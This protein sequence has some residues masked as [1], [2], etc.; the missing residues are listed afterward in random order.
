M[1]LTVVKLTYGI[2]V[3]EVFK[4]LGISINIYS[5]GR[6]SII[7]YKRIIVEMFDISTCEVVFPTTI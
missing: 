1:Y 2:C 3:K 6:K 4:G 7:K 5:L